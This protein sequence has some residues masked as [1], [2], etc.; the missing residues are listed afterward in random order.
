MLGQPVAYCHMTR[1][2]NCIADDMARWALEARATITFWDRQVPE[3]APGNQLQDVYK[4]Q[5]MK[6]WLDW[7]SLPKPFNWMTNQPNPQLDITV[8]TVFGQRYAIRVAQ[9]YL[10]EAQCKAM[11][12]LCKVANMDEGLPCPAD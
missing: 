12:W 3:D 1:D 10:W 6:P 9:L 7:A 4:Q 8:A 5:G 2:A 11:A